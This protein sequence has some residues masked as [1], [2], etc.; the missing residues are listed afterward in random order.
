MPI[1]NKFKAIILHS[2]TSNSQDDSPIIVKICN[3]NNCFDV[4]VSNHSIDALV[5]M[6]SI[7]DNLNIDNV[8]NLLISHINFNLENILPLDRI[9]SFND[10]L[11][12]ALI[13]ASI[14]TMIKES[15]DSRN[16]EYK[17]KKIHK[18]IFS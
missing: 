9:E 12:K 15:I 4:S 5:S 18:P 13:T 2:F 10:C 6:L 16:H 11:Y 8:L 1:K 7:I 14:K 17:G 3:G